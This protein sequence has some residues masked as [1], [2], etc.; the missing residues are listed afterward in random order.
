MPERSKKILRQYKRYLG[1]KDFEEILAKAHDK[2]AENQNMEPKEVETLGNFPSFM[3][4]VEKVYEEYE[5]RLKVAARNIEL[6]S[7]ELTSAF[8]AVEKLNTSI[9]AML[10]SLG[11]GLLFFDEEGICSEIYSKAC[12]EIFDAEPSNMYLPK[13]L[14]FDPEQTQT[15]QSWL[16]IIFSN[17]SAMSFD[18]LKELLP[19]EIVNSKGMI[20][21]L[22]YK[23]MYVVENMLTGILLIATDVTNQK[24]A[25]KKIREIQLNA[26]KLESI[27]SDR[28]GFYGFLT[29]LS[30]FV[31]H[32]REIGFEEMLNEQKD[33][34]L[35]SLHTFK[36][37][38]ASF[39]LQILPKKIHNLESV[40]RDNETEASKELETALQEFK[41]SIDKNVQIAQQL[42]GN[43][44]MSQKDVK[45]VQ[46]KQLEELNDTVAKHVKDE[47]AKKLIQNY[48]RQELLSTPIFELFYPFRREIKRLAEEQGKPIPNVLI[49][50]ENI[51]IIPSE[52]SHF[53][54]SLIH[55]ARNIVDHGLETAEQR[56]SRSKTPQGNV[57]VC[58]TPQTDGMFEVTIEDDGR[59]I[60]PDLIRSVLA[61]KD[62][63]VANE[64][65]EQVINHIYDYQFSSN[66]SVT[67]TSGRGIGMNAIQ[68]SVT[69]MGGSCKVTSDFKN[70]KGSKFYFL[71]PKND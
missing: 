18:D 60:N 42:F 69:D 11:Q 50:G 51:R 53:F 52:Y 45:N 71:L 38:A 57:M 27:A 61:K 16:K 24:E 49:E 12:I 64:N 19:S 4:A 67:E 23:P 8:H 9:N 15:F 26:K 36:G 54:K 41:A 2:L 29:D 62:I 39:N 59:G 32:I 21:E 65:D 25:E 13:F 56:V 14:K 63:D 46:I 34:M 68:E 40:I 44:F 33:V 3:D 22:D 31:D 5:E 7:K 10:D 30:N 66:T 28:N 43:E 37:H 55:L 17:P 48:I 20:I 6:S 58:I 70:S 1:A 47:A 35:R